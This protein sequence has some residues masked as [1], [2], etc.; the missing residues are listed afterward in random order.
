MDT[1][2][3]IKELAEAVLQRFSGRE[4]VYARQNK[5]GE[6][7]PVREQLTVEK[8]CEHFQG[9][10]TFGVYTV[11]IDNT[12]LFLIFD[13]DGE[14][15]LPVR[16]VLASIE[17][18]KM[19][20]YTEKTGGRGFHVC[21]FF[22][23][24]IPA[25][26]VIALSKLIIEHAD[27]PK[28]IEVF[29]KQKEA[30]NFGNLIKL[31]LGVHQKYGGRSVFLD[32][33]FN[34]IQDNL[35]FLKEVLLIEENV[36]D[37]I[38]ELNEAVPKA[39]EADENA[40]N[41]NYNLDP[42]NMHKI[43]ESCPHIKELVTRASAG[44]HVSYPDWRGLCG[45]CAYFGAAG[46]Q[47]FHELSSK[48]I[49]SYRKEDC[50]R[51]LDDYKANSHKPTSCEYFACGKDPEKDCGLNPRGGHKQSPIRF[52]LAKGEKI[53]DSLDIKPPSVHLIDIEDT[54]YTKKVVSTQVMV[55]ATGSTF[56]I[57][58]SYLVRCIG[59]AQSNELCGSCSYK[60]GVT[61]EISPIDTILIEFCNISK[62]Q[63]IDFQ[64]QTSPHRT[65]PDQY[66]QGN[67]KQG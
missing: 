51:L 38:L 16:S 35:R 63:M 37:E 59:Q 57:P 14:D 12:T 20:G 60:N 33:D 19:K 27:L 64:H 53:Y 13:F 6:Y 39:A 49:K 11:K 7:S 45:I 54:K 44:E 26:K 48:D 22:D 55:A 2:E 10:S 29:P 9:E 3:N 65:L 4:G 46:Q 67:T 15:L 40:Q 5:K 1:H 31:P 18:F 42:I 41:I 36:V 8:V 34:P 52:G 25:L 61:R 50:Q 24:P 56:H 32:P 23:K 43:E 21:V 17:H 30:K 62:D 58:R 47:R 28:K 66:I